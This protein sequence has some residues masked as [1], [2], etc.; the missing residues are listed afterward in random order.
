M[1]LLSTL[2]EVM[3]EAAVG[4]NGITEVSLHDG[5]P[6]TTGANEISGGGYSRISV[7]DAD[8]SA[9]SGDSI[10]LSAQLQFTGASGQ[11]VTHA[12]VY[13][14]STFAGSG[15]LSGDLA[16]NA[17]GEYALA[18]STNIQLLDPA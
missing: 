11:A 15:E 9:A 1:P 10:T 7:T 18:T 8:W 12:G 3:L 2:K 16:F 4:A 5:D 17:A 14:G 6:S 13:V